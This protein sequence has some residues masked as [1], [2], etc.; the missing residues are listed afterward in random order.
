MKL[1]MLTWNVRGANNCDKRKVIKALI[2]KNR[3]DLV[4]LQETKIQ[5]MTTGIVR[6]LGVGRFIEWGAI[7]SRGAAG[8][9][10]VIWDNRMLELVDMQK[11][12]FSI[13]CTFKS[14]EDGFIWTFTGVY[15][16]ILRRER[17][18]FWE[19][20]GAIKGLWNGPWCVAGDFNAILSPEECNRG[21]RLN[22]I[23]RRFAEVKEDLEL[24]DLPMVG[25]PFTWTGG[26][27]NQS[28]SRLDRFLV[29]EEW[30]SHFG[31]AR[32]FLLPRPVSDHFPILMD[33]GGMRRG[34]IPFRFEN[35]WLKAEGVKDLLK[36]WWEEGRFS[37]SAS[38]ILAEKLKFMKA[39]L[40]EWNRNSFGR[41]EYR[42]NTALE[43]MEYWDAKEKTS[44]LSLEELEARNEAKEEYKKWV[45]LEEITWRQKS[46]E[47]WLK[48]GDRNTGFFHKMANAHRRRNNVD[49]IKINGAW[50]TEENDIREGIANAF[51]T[52]LSNPGEWRPSVSGLQFEM[53]EPLD[54][55]A[56]ESPF[57]EEEVRDAL[58]G[59]NGDKAP[60]P[61]GFSMA[62]WIFAWDFVKAD[63]YKLGGKLVQV[64]SQGISQQAKKS[65]WKGGLKSSRGVCGGRQILDAVLIANEAIDST[66]KNNES[67]ILC[68]LD[69]EKAYD[70]VDWN[71]ILTIM[72]KM[73]F[74][75][76]WIRW[77]RWCIS[78]ASFSVMINGTPTGYFQSSR[79]LRQGDPLSP[80][81]FVI[82]MEVFSVFIKR[83]VEGDFLSGC[84][85][86]GRS[87][88]GVLISHLLFADDTLVFCKP[89]QDQLTYLSWL[90]WFEAVS[91]L[92][93]NLEKSELIPVGRVE[94]MDDLAEEFGCS[95]G[96]LPTTYLGMP[97]GAPFKSVTVWD[98]VEELQKKVN[99][100]EETIF[101]QGRKGDSHS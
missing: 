51:K 73:G 21:G 70:K 35:M 57:M 31:D 8:G 69:I 77:I 82:A 92:R 16:P 12:L 60:G 62:F 13:T 98:G 53:L 48:E 42:K 14:C 91:G 7:D 78:T 17:E 5:E 63:A 46:R 55:S 67:G 27:G 100:V 22:S 99:Y 89:S 95:M 40:K 80:Y 86:K 37:G 71:F 56:L 24:K 6:S 49:R 18:S 33:G 28:S 44:R 34:P 25:G 29:N 90:L 85:V 52:L 79:G 65:G 75:E 15:G 96:S 94:S 54:V 66:L 30:D 50:L 43:Q 84:R 81:L 72:K 88:E 61:D 39:K 4:C 38:F 76:K 59:C 1:R 9:I 3:V 36:Q 101:V 83:A 93:I 11:G 19:E 26:A 68:K 64:A 74:G 45:L 58:E 32:Q 97:L 87:Q 20:L 10:V 41:V 23:M 47:V 2:R